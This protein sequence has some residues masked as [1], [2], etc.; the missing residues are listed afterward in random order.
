MPRDATDRNWVLDQYRDYLYLLSRVGLDTRFRAL[1]DNSDVVQQTLLRAHE[2]IGQFRGHSEAELLAWL[3]AILARQLADLAR[4]AGHVRWEKR[5]SLEATLDRSSGRLASWLA[6]EH[7][8]PGQEAQRREQL[9]RLAGALA[10]LPLDQRTAL[11][12]HHL[13]G[14]SVAEVGRRMDRSAGSVAGLLHRGMKALR[15]QIGNS[16]SSIRGG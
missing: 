8:S 3:R 11:E 13:E 7:P 9:L 6:D 14:Y 2:R 15:V 1:A 4:R 12:M 5:Q 16:D 10:T